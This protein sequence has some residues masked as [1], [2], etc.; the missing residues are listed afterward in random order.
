[1]CWPSK[2]GRSDANDSE[3]LACVQFLN[4]TE[5]WNFVD[6]RLE[7]AL[8]A[9]NLPEAQSIGD[10]SDTAQRASLSA[11]KGQRFCQKAP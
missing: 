3:N 5:V 10:L 2:T 11:G 7:A 9:F 1:M 4:G 6:Y 8:G